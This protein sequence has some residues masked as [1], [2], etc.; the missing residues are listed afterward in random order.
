MKGESFPSIR[1]IGEAQRPFQL[2]ISVKDR[3]NFTVDTFERD[4]H[5]KRKISQDIQG[6]MR[7]QRERVTRL[8]AS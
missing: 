3:C 4:N 7:D 2:P 8:V 1:E 6:K 5:S